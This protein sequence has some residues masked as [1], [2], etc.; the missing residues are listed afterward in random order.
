MAGPRPHAPRGT[1]STIKLDEVDTIAS[2]LKIGWDWATKD[3]SGSQQPAS[4]PSSPAAVPRAAA[5]MPRAARGVSAPAPAPPKPAAPQPKP[6]PDVD[7]AGC[8]TTEGE[9]L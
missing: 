5:T 1:P 2:V 8:I 7:D 3:R 9:E 6:A 4:A